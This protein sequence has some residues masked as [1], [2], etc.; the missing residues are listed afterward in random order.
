M[1]ND[2]VRTGSAV[3]RHIL[4]T[5]LPQPF[6]DHS[7][8]L[9]YSDGLMVLMIDLDHND[10]RLERWIALL[11]TLLFFVPFLAR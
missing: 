5:I 7:R 9:T 2:C 8:A 6:L 10:Y 3:A 11:L 4:A 1:Y